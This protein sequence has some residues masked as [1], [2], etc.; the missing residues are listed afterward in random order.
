M[1]LKTIRLFRT[2]SQVFF[3]VLLAVLLV[4]A[5]CSV[6]LGSGAYLTC[7][8]GMLQL[9]L[10]AQELL[11]GT[12]LSGTLLLLLT[13]AL[14]RFFC[15]W[16]CPFGTLLDW[17]QKP[18][19]R[20][21]IAKNKVPAWLNSH[22]N[23]ALKYGI[24]GGTLLTATIVRSP[25]FCA[26]CPVGTV[27]RTAGL[28]G[29][30]I[31]LET[32]VLPLIASMETIQKR[33]W[34]KTLCPIGALLGIFARFSPFK[35]RLP[36]NNCAGCNRCQEACAMDNSPRYEG[37]GKLKTDPTVLKALIEIGIPDAL[38]RPAR[39][40]TLPQSIR[41]TVEAKNRQMTVS[42]RECTRCYACVTACP[43]LQSKEI[44]S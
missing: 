21:R 13:L 10:G 7:S 38:D 5:F 16:I 44:R 12:I 14:G 43:V 28:Q 19:A 29:V 41:N 36:W 3:F 35:V 34:C 27:C 40:D 37:L 26:I 25:A 32:A 17:L 15:G 11:W 6:S 4:G 31:G 22:D 42:S 1:T 24:L 8:L 18:L 39:P 20:F 9:T 2:V 23:R 30:N 33:F